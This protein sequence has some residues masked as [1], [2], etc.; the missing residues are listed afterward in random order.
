MWHGSF[1]LLNNRQEVPILTR[2]PKRV[3]YTEE[4]NMYGSQIER[5]KRDCREIE[6]FIKRQEKR[7]NDKK[8]Y[9]LQKKYDYMKSRVDELEELLAA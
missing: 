8:A 2:N 7:G 9:I 5:L 3:N 4:C 6:Y 1:F